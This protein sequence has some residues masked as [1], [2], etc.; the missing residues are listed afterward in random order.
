[1]LVGRELGEFFWENILEILRFYFEGGVWY[2]EQE[3]RDFFQYLD[4]LLF[5]KVV[6][7]VYD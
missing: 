5:I 4:Q 2:D 1:M 7:E 6:M 3:I